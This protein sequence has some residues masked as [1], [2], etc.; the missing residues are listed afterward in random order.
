[1][2]STHICTGAVLLFVYVYIP[3]T[4]IFFIWGHVHSFVHGTLLLYNM[5]IYMC[6]YL[7]RYVYVELCL[8]V[9]PSQPGKVANPA[10][11]QQLNKENELFAVLVRA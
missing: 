2:V 4:S 10:R 3:G 1:M 6:V 8:H 5:H 11:G 7:Q 9:W